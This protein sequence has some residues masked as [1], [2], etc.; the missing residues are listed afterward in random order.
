ML[1]GLTSGNV[2]LLFVFRSMGGNNSGGVADD[3]CVKCFLHALRLHWVEF[4]NKFYEASGYTI[5]PF[6]LKFAV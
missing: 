3:G 1:M 4:Q 2:A 6:T 5:V